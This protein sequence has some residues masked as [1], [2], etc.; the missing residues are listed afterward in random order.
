MAKIIT[1]NTGRTKEGEVITDEVI[2]ITATVG[3]GGV[4]LEQDVIVV[5]ALLRY[6]LESVGDF[7]EVN[8]PEPTGGDVRTTAAIIK[9]FQRYQNRTERRPVSIDGCI[10]PIQGKT[11]FAYGTNKLWTLYALHQRAMETSLLSGNPNPI[12]AIC[13]RWSAVKTVLENSV[14]SLGLALE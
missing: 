6:A 11:P 13:R 5:Q 12:D 7:Q 9:K 8:I 3:V 14:G 1:L 4:N 2:N 10:D